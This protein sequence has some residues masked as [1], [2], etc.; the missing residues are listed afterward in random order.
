MGTQRRS[1]A[2]ASLGRRATSPT[3]WWLRAV[4]SIGWLS[5]LVLGVV[6][7][8]LPAAGQAA[9]VAMKSLDDSAWVAAWREQALA[10]EHGNGVPKDGAR[11]AVLYCQAAR[12]G[13]AA[14]K[15]QPAIRGSSAGGHSTRSQRC[16]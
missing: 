14:S 9:P 15:V 4:R 10:F 11:A 3:S 2:I 7:M 5:G 1:R 12:L 8:P 16:R 13:D 6:L